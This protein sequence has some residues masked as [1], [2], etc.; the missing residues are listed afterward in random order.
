MRRVV[1]AAGKMTYLG[2]SRL[3]AGVVHAMGEAGREALE[4]EAFADQVG[5]EIARLVGA[6]GARATASA[7]AGIAIAMAACRS[8][9]DEAR[10][11]LVPQE[12][13]GPAR[14][15]IQAGHMVDFGAPVEQVVRLAGARPEHVGSVNRVHPHQLRAALEQSECASV[16]FVISHHTAQGGMLPLAQVVELAHERS[17]PVVV[18]A[19]AEED[20]RRWLGMGADLY[21]FSGHKAFSAPTSGFVCG[22]RELVEACRLQEKGLGRAMK[23]GK[24]TLAGLHAAL[25]EWSRSDPTARMEQLQAKVERLRRRL[26]DLGG[27]IAISVTH[28]RT[29]GIPRLS[30]RASPSTALAIQR[31]LRSGEPKIFTRD[32]GIEAG[33]LEFDPR[34]LDEADCDLIA[35]RI[36][37]LLVT[38]QG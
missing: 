14:V 2:A 19:A 27:E 18:D 5:S 36:E 16:L 35:S 28:D 32:H 30:L 15:L 3:S 17:V 21:V 20:P 31:A 26:G 38:A 25:E 22:T 13:A 6:E 37:E 7:A 33:L 9:A 12:M 29:R 11:S 4:V 10:A 1:N 34:E 23:V 8:G 24:E